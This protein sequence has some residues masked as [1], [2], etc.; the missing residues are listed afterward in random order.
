MFASADQSSASEIDVHASMV[1]YS[2][3]SDQMIE[4]DDETMVEQVITASVDS[5]SFDD[6]DDFSHDLISSP[7][8]LY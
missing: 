5:C 1:I 3:S 4:G 7:G 8:P 2:S 6:I